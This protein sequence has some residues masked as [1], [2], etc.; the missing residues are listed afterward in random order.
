MERRNNIRIQSLILFKSRRC[1]SEKVRDVTTNFFVVF[2]EG[3]VENC[4]D[5]FKFRIHYIASL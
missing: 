1:L 2:P 5:Y 4:F 3:F